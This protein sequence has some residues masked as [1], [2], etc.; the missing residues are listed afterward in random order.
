MMTFTASLNSSRSGGPA[1]Q[2]SVHAK[3]DERRDISAILR[4]CWA[5]CRRL[6]TEWKYRAR[7][8]AELAMLDEHE[9]RDISMTPSS[10]KGEAR[11]PFWKE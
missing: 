2:A 1:D 5:S 7:S 3:P 9:L 6:V 11:K 8:R 4:S 10:A